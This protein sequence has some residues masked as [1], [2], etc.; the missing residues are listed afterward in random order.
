MTLNCMIA[1]YQ[2]KVCN[3]TEWCLCKES[4][5]I[6]ACQVAMSALLIQY[7]HEC[8]WQKLCYSLMT[9]Q[10]LHCIILVCVHTLFQAPNGQFNCLALWWYTKHNLKNQVIVVLEV[11]F[12]LYI[13]L[14]KFHCIA[15]SLAL[16]S[17]EGNWKIQKQLCTKIKMYWKCP[18]LHVLDILAAP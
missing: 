4:Y 1:H 2:R 11:L 7:S 6:E 5:K 13:I 16:N 17:Y 3:R 10:G 15:K 8:N 14:F 12:W 9:E 18:F